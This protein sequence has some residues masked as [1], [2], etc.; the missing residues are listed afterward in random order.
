MKTIDYNAEAALYLGRDWRSALEQGSRRFPSAAKAIRFALEEVP[1]VSLRG[2]LMIVEGRTY[3][4]DD[5]H[6]L[7]D[8]AYYPLGR[9]ADFEAKLSEP[10]EH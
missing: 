8:D 7:Y 6:A 1:P 4:P 2:A 10:S 3:S 5:L 9:K